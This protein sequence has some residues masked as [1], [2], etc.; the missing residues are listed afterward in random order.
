MTRPFFNI[1]AFKPDD[2]QLYHK[3]ETQYLNVYA[4]IYVEY[5]QGKKKIQQTFHC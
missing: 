1:T 4:N 2:S 5:I 3:K